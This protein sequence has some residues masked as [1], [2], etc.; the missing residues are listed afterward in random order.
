MTF[1]SESWR[2]I[3]SDQKTECGFAIAAHSLSCVCDGAMLLLAKFAA[4][5]RL[6]IAEYNGLSG[7]IAV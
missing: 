7:G 4:P 6:R 2:R 5:G 3:P 1:H